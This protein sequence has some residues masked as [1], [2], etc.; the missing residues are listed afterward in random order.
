MEKQFEAVIF[1]LDGTLLD[2]LEDLAAAANRMLVSNGY[3]PHPID[4]YRHFV[5]DGAAM[6]V[7]RALPP[8]V[9]SKE[10]EEKCLAAFLDDYR[11]NWQ[12]RTR[13]YPGITDMLDELKKRGI[14]MAVLSNK[15]HEMTVRCIARYFNSWFFETVLG[16]R[17]QVPKKPDPAGALEVA[18][19]MNLP[20]SAFLYIGD[21]A[22]DMQT[23]RAASMFPVGVRWGF[24]SA[25]ELKKSGARMLINHPLEIM[26]RINPKPGID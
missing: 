15:P 14:R 10:A 20:T 8:V 25:G 22:I 5:G 4:A 18:R 23:A 21:T 13:P 19:H 24:R 9:R 3:P 6:L 17:P 16:Q 1:D 11:Q 7:R 2:T 12:D 26:T